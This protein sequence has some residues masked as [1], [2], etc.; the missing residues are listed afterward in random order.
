MRLMGLDF[1]AHTVGVAV[2]DELGF[3]ASPVETVRRPRESKLRQTYARIEQL[4]VEYGVTEL[5]VG[6]P[7]GLDG[8]DDER[9]LVS[10]EFGEALSRR[11][12][13]PVHYE[14]ERLTTVESKQLLHDLGEG[15]DRVDTVAACYILQ[16]YLNRLDD[17][18]A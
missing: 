1:G 2:C 17:D 12:G 7:T 14:D 9:T 16:S 13:L 11:T 18:R 3:A 15:E 5:V 8:Q 10:R 4:I 6:L